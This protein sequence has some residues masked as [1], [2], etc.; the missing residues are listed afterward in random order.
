MSGRAEVESQLCCSPSPPPSGAPVSVVVTT[1]VS[2]ICSG[3]TTK[4]ERRK[5]R[6]PQIDLMIRSVETLT[7]GRHG[8]WDTVALT[9]FFAQDDR[10]VEALAIARPFRSSRRCILIREARTQ[11]KLSH[12]HHKTTPG[13]PV[14]LTTRSSL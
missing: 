4:P 13:D 9:S 5:G 2:P 1:R 10:T 3:R 14:E 11:R 12:F 8:G 7:R 6:N